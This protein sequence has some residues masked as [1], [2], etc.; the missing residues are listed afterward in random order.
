MQIPSWIPCP[1]YS[2]QIFFISS[3]VSA[4][5]KRHRTLW[6]KACFSKILQ[7][8][9]TFFCEKSRSTFIKI[10]ISNIFFW[11]NQSQ[12][13]FWY[14]L[15]SQISCATISVDSRF[16]FNFM[17]LLCQ[18][19]WNFLGYSYVFSLIMVYIILVLFFIFN[20]NHFI[21]QHAVHSSWRTI[22]KSD[23]EE[24]GSW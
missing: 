17:N 14:G 18:M 12:I 13:L 15:G 24:F 19:I 21:F 3:A 6:R 4:V 16:V 8:A 7:L 11:N 23:D 5:F 1:K 9:E 2:T 22:M 10:N 20:S